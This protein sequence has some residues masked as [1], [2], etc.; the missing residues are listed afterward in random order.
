MRQRNFTLGFLLTAILWPAAV[1]GQAAATSREPVSITRLTPASP[2]TLEPGDDVRIDFRYSVRS[3][4]GF[5][6]FIR[7]M[8]GSAL[9]PGYAASGSQLFS[10]R[11]NG[12]ATFTLRQAGRVDRLRIVVSEDGTDRHLHRSYVDVDYRF[13]SQLQLLEIQIPQTDAQA[14]NQLEIEKPLGQLDL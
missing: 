9:S 1:H 4:R 12:R 5:R 11:G 10:G 14:A 6:I 13:G 2:A 8:T 7:P 3:Q